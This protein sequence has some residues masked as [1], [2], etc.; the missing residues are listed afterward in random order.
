MAASG[1]EYWG[2]EG[3]EVNVR[4]LEELHPAGNNKAAT[5]V[6]VERMTRKR[7]AEGTPEEVELAVK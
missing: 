2:G 4:P 7:K 6:S 5:E 1:G 3:V